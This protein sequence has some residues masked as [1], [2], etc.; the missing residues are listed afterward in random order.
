MADNKPSSKP[1]IIQKRDPLANANNSNRYNSTDTTLQNPPSNA[2]TYQN[3]F[4]KSVQSSYQNKYYQNVQKK[5]PKDTSAMTKIILSPAHCPTMGSTSYPRK[6]DDYSDM[7]TLVTSSESATFHD[8]SS[9]WVGTSNAT[10]EYYDPHHAH[11][12]K[13]GGEILFLNRIQVESMSMDSASEDV[14]NSWSPISHIW[15]SSSEIDSDSSH[16]FD[17]MASDRVAM[18]VRGPVAIDFKGSK[19]K[20]PE[21]IS[22]YSAGSQYLSLRDLLPSKDKSPKG[23]VITESALGGKELGKSIPVQDVSREDIQSFP[24]VEEENPRNEGP[25]DFFAKKRNAMDECKCAIM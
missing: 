23:E 16:D 20:I 2:P 4:Y 15:G 3:A 9:F 10:S 19:P 25:I 5:R 18:E 12:G 13:L 7:H 21:Y 22:F 8:E 11:E 14:G 6:E 17:S 1:I 24:Q